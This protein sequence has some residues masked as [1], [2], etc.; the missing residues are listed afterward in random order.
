MKCDKKTMLLYAVTDRAWVGELSLFEQTE[1][2]LQNGASCVQLREKT[3]DPADFLRE[4]I[5]MKTLCARYGVP[6]IIN[7]NVEIAIESRADGVHVGQDDTDVAEVRRQV[8]NG[9]IIGA[10]AHSVDEARAAAAAGADYLGAGAVF[11]SETKKNANKLKLETLRAICGAVDIPVV[12]IGGITEDNALRLAGSGVAG[13]AVVSALFAAH[14]IAAAAA[15]LRI[16]AE[17]II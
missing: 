8:G 3:L 16:L 15:R 17:K 11:G 6:L 5:E 10:S 2:A 14:D 12:A 7:D 1:L 9:M 4:A 13:I